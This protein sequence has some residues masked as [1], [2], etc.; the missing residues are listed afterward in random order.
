M[1]QQCTSTMDPLISFSQLL[2]L[3][4]FFALFLSWALSWLLSLL[5]VVSFVAFHSV[6]GTMDQLFSK[7]LTHHEKLHPLLKCKLFTSVT[8]FLFSNSQ[9]I[10]VLNVDLVHVSLHQSLGFSLHLQCFGLCKFCV[11]INS[12]L[13]NC[14]PQCAGT[15]QMPVPNSAEL[16]LDFVPD[17][18]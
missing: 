5:S 15:K 3:F 1:P 11:E 17:I 14:V 8:K 10:I 18:Q 13:C 7:I 16:L 2:S 9:V 12:K 6:F 4:L